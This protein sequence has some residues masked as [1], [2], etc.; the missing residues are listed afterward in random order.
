[1]PE[2]LV[3]LIE[4]DG[5]DALLPGH[6]G[7]EIGLGGFQHHVVVMGHQAVGMHLFTP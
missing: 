2:K 7:D 3:P 6:P 1:M 4:P 5:V